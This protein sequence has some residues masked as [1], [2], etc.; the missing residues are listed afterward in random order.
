MQDL[1]GFSQVPSTRRQAV[2]VFSSKEGRA[3]FLQRR[4]WCG[5][6]YESPRR[7]YGTTDVLH[8]SGTPQT[9]NPNQKSSAVV[10]VTTTSQGQ[11]MRSVR[12]REQLT[13]FGLGT[14]HNCQHCAAVPPCRGSVTQHGTALPQ[15]PDTFRVSTK[16]I[17]QSRRK[18]AQVK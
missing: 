12:S 17:Q 18:P 2:P 11:N 14:T 3:E 6:E 4:D 7:E 5:I 16:F 9:S 13:W 10:H 8:R 15:E 1:L